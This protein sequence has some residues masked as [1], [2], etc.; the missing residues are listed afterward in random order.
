MTTDHEVLERRYRRLLRWYPAAY[1]RTRGSEILDTLMEAAGP[2]QRRPA[3]REWWA[4]LLGG[5][6]ARTGADRRLSRSQVWLGGLR[7]GV[8]LLLVHAAA[9]FLVTCG[10]MASELATGRLRL[11]GGGWQVRYGD[12]FVPMASQWGYP[13]ALLLT[14]GALVLLASGR[15]L[16]ALPVVVAGAVAQLWAQSWMPSWPWGGLGFGQPVAPLPLAAVLILP[17]LRWRPPR[18]PRP[19]RWLLAVPVGVLVL[20]T[21]F[22]ASF[23]SDRLFVLVLL[24]ALAWAALDARVPIALSAVLLAYSSTDLVAA[25]L[26]WQGSLY[27]GRLV[28][29]PVPVSIPDPLGPLAIELALVAAQLTAA[30]LRAR[31]QAT[32]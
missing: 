19:W 1:R 11:A 8:L 10:G 31:R 4:L 12:H 32:V 28:V 16:P 20:P 29:P 17:L 6:R 9:A 14:A 27:P 5:L 7:L 25:V 2:G 21:S 23:P 24:G 30:A 22:D 3:G 13:L 15:P 26:Q 18:A